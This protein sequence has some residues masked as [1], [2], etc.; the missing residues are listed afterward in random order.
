MS[1]YFL[2]LN[3]VVRDRYID[4]ISVINHFDPYTLWNTNNIV[5][6][7]DMPEICFMDLVEYFLLNNSFYTSHQLKAYKSLDAFESYKAGFIL[8]AIC[9]KI[10]DHFIVLCEVS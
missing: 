7:S 4:K 5:N 1:T 2:S 8:K 6:I 9:T 10:Q 3:G